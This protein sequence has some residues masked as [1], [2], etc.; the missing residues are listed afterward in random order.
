M[1]SQKMKYQEF[2]KQFS[3]CPPSEY[4][5]V[6]MVA[7]RWVFENCGEESFIPVLVINPLRK[8][9]SNDMNCEGYALSMFEKEIGA[10]DRYKKLVHRNPKLQETF[11]NLIAKINILPTQGK[12][13]EPENNNYTH[14]NFHEYEGTDLTKNIVEI[15]NIFDE[16]GNFKR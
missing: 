11:G 12:A 5:E 16:N 3:N 6:E 10:Y 1:H 15:I 2:L 14:F 8:F 7:F 4:K 9:D 13:S